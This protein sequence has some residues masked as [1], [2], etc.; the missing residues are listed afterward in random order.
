MAE[1]NLNVAASALQGAARARM[2]HEH[3]THHLRGDGEE[4]GAALP[5]RVVLAIE[6]QPGLVHE[7]RG[8]ERVALALAAQGARRLPAKLRVHQRHE[9]LAGPRVARPPRVQ[10]LG[11][12]VPARLSGGGRRGCGPGGQG[13][14]GHGRSELKGKP[15]LLG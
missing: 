15:G 12:R 4:L 8:L 5:A 7:R 13:G 6:A 9:R 1:R 11:D 14:D 3:A 2:V 10:E